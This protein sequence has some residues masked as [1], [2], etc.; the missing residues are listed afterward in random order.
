VDVA[1][2]TASVTAPPTMRLRETSGKDWVKS[3]EGGASVILQS[4]G[5]EQTSVATEPRA[6]GA[7][8]VLMSF[9]DWRP[10]ARR[11]RHP[12]SSRISDSRSG[13]SIMT[14]WPDGTA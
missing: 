6:I 2:A 11:S 9:D 13:M 3:A 4:L 7:G 14:S 1:T 8:A 10:S 5:G 12:T